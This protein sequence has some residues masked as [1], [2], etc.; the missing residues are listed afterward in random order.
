M[1]ERRAVARGKKKRAQPQLT[2]ER[3]RAEALR[4]IEAEGLEEF[5]TRKLGRAL[6]VE[7]MAI[8]WYYPSKEALLD[9]VV[10]S[11]IGRMGAASFPEHGDWIDG[12]RKVAYAYRGL[13]HEF[14]NSFPLLALRRFATEQTYK[15]LDDLFAAARAE[16]YADRTTARFYRLVASYC[17]GIALNELAARKE[18]PLTPAQLAALK[19]SFPN[20]VG[21]RQWDTPTHFDDV[22]AFGLE[23]LLEALQNA[24]RKSKPARSRR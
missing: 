4:L 3:V 5:S 6:G 10:E 17:S 15:F 18:A 20:L 16:G 23:V 22:F 21:V 13:A 2:A 14:P 19:A 12:L 8:Y 9:A 24:P 11:L 7:A 1:A